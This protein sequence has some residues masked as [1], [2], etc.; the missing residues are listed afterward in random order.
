MPSVR[1]PEQHHPV[2]QPEFQSQY[3]LRVTNYC[4]YVSWSH[5]TRAPDGVR[6]INFTTFAH[7]ASR[8]GVMGRNSRPLRGF[9]QNS[10]ATNSGLPFPFMSKVLHVTW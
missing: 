8:R 6:L 4:A 3:W 5:R 7:F 1:C 2:L 10:T 9:L